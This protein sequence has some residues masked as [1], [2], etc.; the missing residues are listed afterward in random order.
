MRK[1]LADIARIAL[2]LQTQDPLAPPWA[3]CP[4]YPARHRE[5]AP[6][7]SNQEGKG[8]ETTKQAGQWHRQHWR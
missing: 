6:Q 8:W 7:N 2:G 1:K 4:H 3:N 5:A